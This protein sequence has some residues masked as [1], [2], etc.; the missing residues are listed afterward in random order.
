[1]NEWVPKIAEWI[2]DL[3]DNVF[4]KKVTQEDVAAAKK[5]GPR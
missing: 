2:G 3:I 1:L 5:A 4:G